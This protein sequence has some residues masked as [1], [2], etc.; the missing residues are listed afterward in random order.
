M[1]DDVESIIGSGV[2]ERYAMGIATPREI[3]DVVQWSL[4]YPAVREE[5][6]EIIQA[7]DTYAEMRGKVPRPELK[8]RILSAVFSPQE[9]TSPT[10]IDPGHRI[11]DVVEKPDLSFWLSL[12]AN[13]F[14]PAAYDNIHSQRL[15]KTPQRTT[16][17]VWAQRFVP[18]EV[19]TDIIERFMILQGACTCYFNGEEHVRMAAGDTLEIP[20][21]VRHRLE[22]TSSQ[23]LQA[24]VQKIVV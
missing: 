5:L 19:H 18:E 13:L 8:Q 23:P 14:P 4:Q 10:R 16:L 22:I 1:K 7:L 12:T 11:P 2:L 17:V 20:L 24:I 21:H 9:S 15:E 3:R 6:D